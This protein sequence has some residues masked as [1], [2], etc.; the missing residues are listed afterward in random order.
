MQ[1]AWFAF[2]TTC[3]SFSHSQHSRSL[4]HLRKIS[5][6]NFNQIG[7]DVDVVTILELSVIEQFFTVDTVILVWGEAKNS[8]H[9]FPPM[10]IKIVFHED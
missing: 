6:P 2:T 3:H 1:F 5:K 8:D 4:T 7:D 10:A 9:I